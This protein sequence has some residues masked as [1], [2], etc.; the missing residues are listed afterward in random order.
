MDTTLIEISARGLVLVPVVMA[1]V[2][3]AKY[4]IDSYWAPL[5]SLGIGVVAAYLVGGVTF[6]D[7]T[8]MGGIVVG[9]MA[10]GLYSGVARMIPV[11]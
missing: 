6:M 9:L 10:S 7:S 1:L 4:Y 3:L 2:S 8:A 11:K 5:M